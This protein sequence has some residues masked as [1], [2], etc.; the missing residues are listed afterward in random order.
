MS[1]AVRTVVTDAFPNCTIENIKPQN[2]RP[3]NKTARVE[4]A[5]RG[6]VYVKVDL[7]SVGRVRREIAGVRHASTYASVNVPEIVAAD[8]DADSPYMITRPLAGELMNERWTADDDREVLMHAVGST[9]AATH[10]ARLDEVG[11]I[12]GW[13]DGR[14]RLDAMSWTETLCA[15]VRSRAESEFSNRFSE[16]PDDLVST[17]RAINPTLKVD[18]ASLLHGD[19]SRINIHL[20]PNGLLDWERALVGDPA[21]DLVETIFHH[22]GQPDVD[23]SEKP[24]L[25]EALLAGYREQRGHLP[26]Q[27]DTYEPLYWAIAYLLAP[28]TFDKWAPQADAPT[29]EIEE[30]VRE[31]AYSR[32]TAAKDALS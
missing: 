23:E 14:L 10:E 26:E 6:P 15:T 8:P 1:S 13:A 12:T 29:D 18:S 19:P 11:I 20:E 5:D 21:F 16:L 7:N 24:V 3:G 27:F 28:Q 2:A 17:I 30:D 32:M 31:E 22:L 9:V 4:F 25:R